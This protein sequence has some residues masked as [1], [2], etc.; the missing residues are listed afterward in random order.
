MINWKDY[1]QFTRKERN[2][3]IFLIAVIVFVWIAY[4]I[5]DSFFKPNAIDTA[6]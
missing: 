5:I 6:I 1:F 4:F 2:G 3:I